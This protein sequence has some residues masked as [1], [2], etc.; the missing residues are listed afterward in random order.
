MT[1]YCSRSGRFT[2]RLGQTVAVCYDG[3]LGRAQRGVVVAVH[4]R[5][6]DVRFQPWADPESADVVMRVG[7]R[8]SR[9]PYGGWISGDGEHGIMRWLGCR[10][11]WYS[12]LPLEH[13]EHYGFSVED[14]SRGQAS[15]D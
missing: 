10:G 13:L 8:E 2:P 1:M 11:D 15:V 3:K 6:F 4:R 5:S 12:V 14:S 7:R 9:R